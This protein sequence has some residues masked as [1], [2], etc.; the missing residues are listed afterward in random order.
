[1]DR[2]EAE[3]GIECDMVVEYLYK[4]HFNKWKK[5]K[6]KSKTLFTS[7]PLHNPANLE[8]LMAE[9]YYL[10]RKAILCFDTGSFAMHGYLLKLKKYAIPNEFVID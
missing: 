9:V 2:F 10:M 1:M 4:D 5:L 8:I 3:V 6:P 7:S